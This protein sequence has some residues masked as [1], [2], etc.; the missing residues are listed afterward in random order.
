MEFCPTCGSML[1]YQLPQL[2][3]PA[4]FTCPTCPY[5]CNIE[6]QVKIKRHVRLVKKT[7]DPIFTKEDR[8]NFQETK[9]SCPACNHDKAGFIQVQTR[10]ADEPMTIFYECRKCEYTWREG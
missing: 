2:G 6:S 7:M 5:V 3:H 8:R 9:E 4:R 1:L 10:S